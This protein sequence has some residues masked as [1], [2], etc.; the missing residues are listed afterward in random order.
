MERPF[1]FT[2][3]L[4]EVHK[5]HRVNPRAAAKL[6]GVHITDDWRIII[7]GD[8]GIVMQNAARDMEEYFR[9]SMDVPVVFAGAGDSAAKSIWIGL[10]ATL[11]E[12]TFRLLVT[13]DRIV[14]TG[15]D[16]RTAAQGSYA[17]EDALNL[18]EAP[19]IAPGEQTMHIR[20]APRIIHG[21]MEFNQYPNEHLRMLAHAGISGIKVGTSKVLTDPEECKRVNDIID[22]ALAYGIDTYT[23][24]SIHNTMHPDD[25]GAFRHY[26]GLYGRFVELLPNLK[27]L[28]IVGEACEFPS[29]DPRTT[30][31]SWRESRF[32][33]KPSPG[34]FPCDDYP[35]FVTMVRDVIRAHN[36]NTEL[37][38]WT[39][40]WGFAD[41]E[42]RQ[43]LLRKVPADITMMATFEMF[44]E[45][46]VAPGIFE[47]IVD[48]S[49]YMIGPG[50]YFVSES[51]INKERGIRMYTMANTGGNT[52]DMGVV[53]YLPAPQRWMKR[54]KAVVAAQDNLRLDGVEESHSYGFWP[55][56]M[57]EL[58]KYA[59]MTPEADLEELLRRLVVRDFGEENADEVVTAFNLFSEGI[60]HCV[61]TNPDQWGPARVGPTYPLVFRKPEPRPIGPKGKGDP[62]YES[63]VIYKYRLDWID[64][65]R[66]ET[67]EY[68]TMARLYDAGC[69][70][71]QNVISRMTGR[72][73][74][75]A[76]FLLGVAQFIGNTARTIHHVK[77]WHD[78]KG[79]LGVYLDT[80]P[81]WIGGNGAIPDSCPSEKPLVRTAEDH[82]PIILELIDIAKREIHNTAATIPLVERDSRLGYNQE[83]SYT[84]SPEQLRWKIDY[85]RRVI[86]EELLPLLTPGAEI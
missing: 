48:Y 83:F 13:E 19:I 84:A 23:F 22:R 1:E 65:L 80:N 12:R 72:K 7:S 2:K 31:K 21:G 34:W 8:A 50:K 70:I 39:Y 36:P 42:L 86:R 16:D 15:S 78:L 51:E 53:P 63:N 9:V 40:N 27:G 64:K 18:N 37:V 10:D 35:Q 17:L 52:W 46:E 20:F 85:M 11:P 14:I 29:K 44:E 32:D 73:A 59:Y 56:I 54:W 69:E 76:K 30:G 62:N 75:D 33:K 28:V 49:L 4:M 25:P 38:F 6:T 5:P 68:E 3:R 43:A 82:I 57:P 60:A 58:V 77:R 24:S 81:I 61:S 67:K 55:S 66:Y 79:Q 74:E 41:K 47:N 26:E 45:E 71:L